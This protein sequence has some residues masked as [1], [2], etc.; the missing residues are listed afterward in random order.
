MEH[1]RLVE[2]SFDQARVVDVAVVRSI[3]YFGPLLDTLC[4]VKAALNRTDMDY[5]GR[6]HDVSMRSRHDSAASSSRSRASRIWLDVG[7]LLSWQRDHVT[8][9]QR[10][11]ACVAAEFLKMR[12]RSMQI[13]FCRHLEEAGFIE[14]S[15]EKLRPCIHR[16]AGEENPTPS[17]RKFSD[18]LRA[19]YGRLSRAIEPNPR[20]PNTS[21]KARVKRPLRRIELWFVRRWLRANGIFR[22]RDILLNLGSSWEHPVQQA[23]LAKIRRNTDLQYVVLIHDLIPWRLPQFFIPELV[24]RFVAWARDTAI[25]ADR[26]LVTS[27]C[28]RDDLLAFTKEFEIREKPITMVRLGR[29][30]TSDLNTTIPVDLEQIPAGFVLC[31]GTVEPRK[32]HRLLLRTWSRLL[33]RNDRSVV[34]TLIWAGREGWMVDELLAEVA[35]SNFLDGRLMWLG[36]EGGLSDSALHG[37]YRAC[38]FTM[39][40]SIYE[41]WGL[42]VSES[43]AHG[44]FCIASNA[45]SIPEIGGDLVDYHGP[46]DLEECLA[47]AERA[48]FDPHY[49]AVKEERIRLDYEMPSWVECSQAILKACRSSESASND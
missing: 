20:E 5:G 19:I 31:V 32:N 41:G 47:L 9:I 39:F 29:E 12:S 3:R 35:A 45:S 38:L 28:S 14:V 8:G 2:A 26:L 18:Q 22:D 43:L 21:L 23:T 10:V 33:Q 44:K 27:A 48:I 40:P 49:R 7:D 37:L 15:A 30:K 16:L 17:P 6:L 13:R 42:P 46:E 4:R 36:R 25:S 1:N 11:M 24:Q 34:P